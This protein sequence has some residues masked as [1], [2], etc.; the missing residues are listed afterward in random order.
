MTLVFVVNKIFNV[1]KKVNRIRAVSLDLRGTNVSDVRVL[2]NI[3]SLKNT[4][5]NPR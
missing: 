3:G 5:I 4:K 2:D 1:P